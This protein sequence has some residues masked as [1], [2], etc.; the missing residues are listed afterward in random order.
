MQHLNYLRP[1]Y[2]LLFLWGIIVPFSAFTQNF[3]IS[4]Y[5]YDDASGESL[6]GVTLQDSTTGKGTTSNE[7][8][9]YTLVLTEGAHWLRFSY[10]GFQAQRKQINLRQ[11]KTLNIRLHEDGRMIEQVVIS[12][13]ADREKERVQNTEMGKLSVPIEILRRTPVLFGESDLIKAIQLLPGV[14]RGGE[15]SVGMFV[16]GGGNDENLIL[17]DEAPVYNVGHALGFLSVFNTNSIKSVDLYK[18]AFPAQ[19]GGRLSS[20]LDVR[21]REGN[22]QRFGAQGSIGNIASNLTVEAPIVKNRGSFILSGRRSYIDK[23]V[24]WLTPVQFPY[25]FYDFNAKVNY[26]LNDRDRVY[27]SSYI[28]RDVI[29][30]ASE[31]NANDSLDFDANINSNLGNFTI[32][33]RWNHIYPS[34]K[35]FHN[36]TLL[37]SQ[38]DY[39]LEGKLLENN[40]L[41]SSSIRDLGLKLD[42]DYRPN[43]QTTYKFGLNLIN[44]VFRPN[45]VSVQGAISDFLKSRPAAKIANQEL[46]AYG[47]LDKDL[48]DRWKIN[49]GLRISASAVQESFYS[50]VE[51]RLAVRYQLSESHSL[52]VGYARMA[53]YLHLVSS[54]S[55][56]LPTDLWY[57]VTKRIPPG[58][59]DQISA[60]YF[61]YFKVSEKHK[62]EFSTE[63][64]YKKLHRLIEY[65][66]GARLLLNDNYE[67]ELV[68]GNGT[69]YGWEILVQKNTGRLTGWMGY[70]LSWSQRQF[71]DLNKGEAYYAR[72]DRRHDVSV[73]ANYDIWRRFGV[74]AAWVYSSGSP[75]TPVVSKYLQPFPNYSGIDLL[76]VYSSKN[77][78]RLHG[79]QRLDIDLVFRGKKRPRWQGEWHLGAYNALNRTQPN[80]VVLTLDETTG[81]EKYQERGLFGFMMSLSYNFKF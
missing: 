75:F 76:P 67:D 81:R 57:P 69:S 30:A 79:A 54:S 4:G 74:S 1:I 50:N 27:V 29:R 72:Y 45:L 51:P 14:K 8:G 60:G 24:K 46:A 73:V 49:G 37:R 20:I 22:D 28:G 35:L 43:S 38:F 21:M 62:V 33:T 41:I 31:E 48:G 15:G 13:S 26:K 36:L 19:Y 11:N 80:R 52:K 25:Y 59:S 71:P 78:Y 42:Y 40:V 2:G 68:R 18:G 3:T 55:V 12:A 77:A 53:Q 23:L 6:A 58:Q 64:Y 66:E 32:T 65:R 56:A 5:V 47:S 70:T 34:G 63:V 17:L 39:N 7:Y 9:F 10:I 61:T 16:R 44:H